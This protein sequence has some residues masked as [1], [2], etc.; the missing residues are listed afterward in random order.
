LPE[1]RRQVLPDETR[2]P[3]W[4]RSKTAQR[5]AFSCPSLAQKPASLSG[6][7]RFA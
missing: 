1:D 3:I 4:D 7:L 6:L 2:H 5:S